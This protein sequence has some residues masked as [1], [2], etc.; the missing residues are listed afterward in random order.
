MKLSLRIKLM[1]II[2]LA[3]VLLL[4]VALSVVWTMGYRH[5]VSHQ[6][7]MFQSEASHVAHNLG[8][9][10]RRN[11][12]ALEALATASRLGD[13]VEAELPAQKDP[14]DLEQR[15]AG[16]PVESPE[17]QAILQNPVSR[18][19]REFCHFDPIFVEVL[20]ADSR[21]RLLGASDRTSD[22]DQ[23]DEEW[24][25]RAIGFQPGEGLLSGLEYDESAGVFSLDISFPVF[26]GNSVRPVGV[27]K[28]VV[29]ASPLFS[30]VPVFASASGASGLVATPGGQILLQ[31]SGREFR[32]SGESLAPD[33]MSRMRPDRAGWFVGDLRGRLEMV[34]FSPV[35]LL[36]FFGRKSEIVGEPLYV[37]VSQPADEIVVPLR[38]R[39]AVTMA[40]GALVILACSLAGIFLAERN[41]MRPIGVLRAA[42]RDLV[43]TVDDQRLPSGGASWAKSPRT[44]LREIA[45]VRT[46]D[47]MEDLA[48]DFSFMAGKLLRYQEDLKREIDA[49][50]REIRRDLDIAREFQQ[51]FLPRDYPSVPSKGVNDLLTLNFHH[52]YQAAM[53]VS[54]DFF[55]LIKLNDHSVGVLIAD[56]MG[57]GTRSALVTAI[58]RTLLHGL[59]GSG[60]DP[61][62]FLA[63]LNGHF[64]EAMQ[65]TDQLVFVSACYVVFD[66]R[67]AT[68]RCASA[69]HPSPLV[70]N[71]NSGQVAEFYGPLRGNP[72][73]GLFSR[74]TY[75][76]FTRPLEED[77]VLLLYTDGVV[78]A[79]NTDDQD[80]GRGRLIDAVR[81]SLECDVATL[82]Q[83]IFDEVLAFT[84]YLSPSDDICLVAVEAVPSRRATLL[85]NPQFLDQVRPGD[86]EAE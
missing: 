81:R 6:G 18:M 46:D 66:T 80:F 16:L 40:G 49:K 48:A 21:G 56:V 14:G 23:S 70:G 8:V 1:G 62:A 22:Y 84:G 60:R 34:G 28:A 71:R 36:G 19:L 58:L 54:G 53:S 61:G 57:H 45:S 83:E 17:I 11:V 79:M 32:P 44:I 55:D 7:A 10:I 63:K 24:W 29:N 20:V 78:E 26:A 2:V 74:H 9:A 31:L 5:R 38:Q 47:E 33:V 41:I 3:G 59:A 37:L 51:A 50:T 64:F 30:S 43:R 52:V 12:T 82:T 35:H 15:W 85:R 4:L 68:V 25:Q 27:L 86:T 76:V 39:A 69:G 42:A 67:D 72:A 13:A 65:Q 73:L 77:D 75:D